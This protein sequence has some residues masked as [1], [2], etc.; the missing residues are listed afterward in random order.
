MTHTGNQTGLTGSV[1]MSKCQFFQELSSSEYPDSN[2]AEGGIGLAKSIQFS[3]PCSNCDVRAVSSYS[4]EEV[5]SKE[6]Y[7]WCQNYQMKSAFHYWPSSACPALLHKRSEHLF[8]VLKFLLKVIFSDAVRIL[9]YAHL[10]PTRAWGGSPL[11]LTESSN[12]QVCNFPR[13]NSIS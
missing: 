7:G 6:I 1:R 10:I 3:P 2:S 11:F 12:L 9:F 5:G 4:L 13:W 8:H